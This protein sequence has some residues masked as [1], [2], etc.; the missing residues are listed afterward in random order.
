[1]A[2]QRLFYSNSSTFNKTIYFP[3]VIIIL[4]VKRNLSFIYEM[5]VGVPLD[6]DPSHRERPIWSK[7]NGQGTRPRTDGHR[8]KIGP[9]ACRKIT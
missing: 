7:P 1:M 6:Q 4:H 9:R 3:N 8:G 2:I 5:V